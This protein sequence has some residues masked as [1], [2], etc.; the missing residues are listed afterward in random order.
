[1]FKVEIYLLLIADL[2]E[3]LQVTFIISFVSGLASLRT[4]ADII[5]FLLIYNIKAN[6]FRQTAIKIYFY[7]TA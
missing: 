2:L 7:S 5:F 1:M 3:L 6:R 4:E